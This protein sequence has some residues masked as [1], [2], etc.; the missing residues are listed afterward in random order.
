ME[1]RIHSLLKKGKNK[2]A[3]EAIVTAYSERLY[4]HIRRML[5]YHADADDVL[6]NTYIKIWKN[7]GSYRGDA[8]IY[9]WLYRIA[10]NEALAHIRSKK[11]LQLV[12]DEDAPAEYQHLSGDIYFDAEAASAKLAEAVAALPDKQRAVFSL[13]YFEEM[14]YEEM[15]EVLNTSVGALK[16]SYH[17][18]VKKIRDFLMED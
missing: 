18:A 1:E 17:H 14:K 6:Q 9:T 12:G 10:T 11:N 4:W 2:Q 8:K 7:I 3:F 16:A 5:H 15:A 13:K